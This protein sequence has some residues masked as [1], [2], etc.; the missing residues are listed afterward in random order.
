MMRVGVLAGGMETTHD[1]PPERIV[2]NLRPE[3]IDMDFTVPPA[4]KLMI[5][6]TKK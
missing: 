1:A 6:E 3:D 4:R 5:V 2:A